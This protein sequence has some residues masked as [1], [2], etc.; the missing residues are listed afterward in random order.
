MMTR[1]ERH[2]LARTVLEGLAIGDAFGELYAYGFENVRQRVAQGVPAGPWWWTDDTAMALGVI[3]CLERNGKI[4]EEMLA[5]IF[6]RNYKREPD[7]GYGKGARQI[8]QMIG[9][10]ESWEKAARSAFGGGSMG[11]GAAMRVAPLGAWFADDLSVVVTQAMKSARVTHWH[12][13]GIAGAIAVAVA[14]ACAW[15]TRALPAAEAREVIGSEVLR[16]T[17]EGDTREGLKAAMQV[18]P[19]L[20]P[21]VAGRRLGNGALV[22]APDTVPY[23]IWSALRSLDDYAGALIATVEGGGD[24]DTNGAM[25]G[26]ILAARLGLDTIP[27]EWL[28]AREALP[29][30][31]A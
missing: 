11:N 12:P 9:G 20:S 23:V 10:G 29:P 31:V 26:G 22:T 13:E 18:E 27:K 24:C 25:V 3:E 17:P 6:S 19:M 5:W 2:S 4:E 14:T 1:D 8:L 16:L 28:E 30:L 21:A 15:Q 7:R